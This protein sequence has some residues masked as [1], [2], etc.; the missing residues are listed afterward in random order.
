[1]KLVLLVL[2]LALAGPFESLRSFRDAPSVREAKS[3]ALEQYDAVSKRYG[4]L[5]KKF[6][7]NNWARKV[8]DN[9]RGERGTGKK[10][11]FTKR[12]KS[13]V[14]EDTSAEV[15]QTWW[16]HREWVITPGACKTARRGL[17]LPLFVHGRSLISSSSTKRRARAAHQ[18]ELAPP[19]FTKR[20]ARR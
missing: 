5:D 17:I 11:I 20:L 8:L 9:L 14:S 10:Y 18:S 6:N 7:I 3:A 12:Q 1:M 2:P 16:F 4:V 15:L 19:K 13:E